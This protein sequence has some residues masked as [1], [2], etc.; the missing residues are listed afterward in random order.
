MGEMQKNT[1]KD[2][3][4]IY[5]IACKWTFNTAYT[6]CCSLVLYMLYDMLPVYRY[7]YIDRNKDCDTTKNT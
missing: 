5:T 3:V 1:Y 7:R 4:V 6:V 2:D